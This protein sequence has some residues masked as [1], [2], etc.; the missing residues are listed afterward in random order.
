MAIQYWLSAALQAPAS[1]V[2]YHIIMTI[3]ILNL[4][5]GIAYWRQRFHFDSVQV[6]R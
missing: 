3:N 5:S 4:C 2:K 6:G 1:E